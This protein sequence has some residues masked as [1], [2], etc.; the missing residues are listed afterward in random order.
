M[1]T[2]QSLFGVGS[3]AVLNPTVDIAATLLANVSARPGGLDVKILR[4]ELDALTARDPVLASQ[5]REAV[6]P[7]L[8][9]TQRAE[10]ERPVTATIVARSSITGLTLTKEQYLTSAP[11]LWRQIQ[12]SAAGFSNNRAVSTAARAVAALPTP[13]GNIVAD[14]AT[15]DFVVSIASVTANARIGGRSQEFEKTLVIAKSTDGETL[16]KSLGLVGRQGGTIT[17]GRG[18]TVVHVHYEGLDQPPNKADNSA[19]KFGYPS[20]IIGQDGKVW[21][22]GRIEGQ[23]QVRSVGDNGRIGPWQQF[24]E[25]AAK[26][27]GF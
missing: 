15:R 18:D 6:L 9:V 17:A 8:S 25:D 10:L 1:T 3:T 13:K 20:F 27:R 5:V 22:V 16:I 14:Q 26:Y 21:E 23:V 2:V 11:Q 24:Q 12:G 19:A 4:S 7:R